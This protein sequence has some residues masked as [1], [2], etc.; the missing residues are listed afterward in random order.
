VTVNLPT[1]AA[2][3]MLAQTG[4]LVLLPGGKRNIDVTFAPTAPGRALNG[5]AITSDD[6]R[7]PLI[8]VSVRGRGR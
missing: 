6:P 7:A 3:Y 1:L 5:L 2:P 4:D 8:Q